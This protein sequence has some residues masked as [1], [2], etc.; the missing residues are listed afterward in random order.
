MVLTGNQTTAF[1]ENAGQMGLTPRMRNKLAEEG[2]ISVN[3]LADFDKDI[4]IQVAENLR[5]PGGRVADPDPNANL[6]VTIPTPPFIFGAKSQLRLNAATE[7]VR[8]HDTV[9]RALTATGLQ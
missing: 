3:D 6:G 4:V 7:L 1:F 5:R 9:G 2:I 8:Y